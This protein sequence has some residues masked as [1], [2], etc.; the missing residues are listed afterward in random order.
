MG[1]LKDKDMRNYLKKVQ[2]RM[3][4]KAIVDVEAQEVGLQKTKK[5]TRK[6]ILDGSTPIPA[7]LLT[8]IAS[9]KSTIGPP[10]SA[11]LTV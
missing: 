4:A 2:K 11:S 3:A 7:V 1:S 9:N 6:V 8:T 5:I 10:P